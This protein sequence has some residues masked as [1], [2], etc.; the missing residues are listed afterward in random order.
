[1]DTMFIELESWIGFL[2]SSQRLS[3]AKIIS[4]TLMDGRDRGDAE[5]CGT[6]GMALRWVKVRESLIRDPT[7]EPGG[8]EKWR[9]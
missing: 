8:S 2:D 6:C 4:K 1:M 3:G 7:Q 9:Y 5:D